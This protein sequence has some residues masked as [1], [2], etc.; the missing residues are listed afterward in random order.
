MILGTYS[1]APFEYGT[2]FERLDGSRWTVQVLPIPSPYDHYDIGG[3]SCPSTRW[4][5]AVGEVASGPATAHGA[6]VWDGSTWRW[7]VPATLDDNVPIAVSCPAVR[8]CMVTGADQTGAFTCTPES[9]ALNGST[10]PTIPLA[11]RGQCAAP[12]AVSCP[13]MSA[14]MTVGQDTTIEWRYPPD[15]RTL[16]RHDVDADA[17][18]RGDELRHRRLL[19]GGRVLHCGRRARR[20]GR[21]VERNALDAREHVSRR[22][23]IS[24]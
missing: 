11:N 16:G 23:G 10:W 7:D 13:S 8:H 20:P 22:H 6:W 12:F 15:R 17:D 4:C 9:L 19:P 2:V 21:D 24:V 5:F 1:P 14:C 3:L 18:A